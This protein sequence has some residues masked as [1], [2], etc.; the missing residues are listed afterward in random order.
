M[1]ILNNSKD[2]LEYIPS[3][4]LSSCNSIKTFNF[5]TLYTIPHLIEGLK[6]SVSLKKWQA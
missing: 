5:F 2:M 4:S 3:R 6:I 1:W